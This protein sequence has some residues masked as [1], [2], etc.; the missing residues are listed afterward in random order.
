[1]RRHSLR[2]RRSPGCCTRCRGS[3]AAFVPLNTRLTAAERR[4]QLEDCGA[5]LVLD[6]PPDG[7]EADRTLA[8]G[9]DAASALAVLYTSGT[10]AQPKQVELTH[11]NFLASALASAANLGVEPDDR[12]LCPMPLFHVGG[13]SILVR[14]AIYG[15][16]A[17]L[18]DGFDAAA[19]ADSLAG[20]EATIV[21]LVATML[22]RLRDAGLDRTPR[23]RA[24]LIGGGPVPQGPA[25]VGRGAGDSPRPDLRPDRDDIAGRDDAPRGRRSETRLGR[26]ATARSPAACRRRWG[27]SGLRSDGDR[28]RLATHRRPGSTRCRG[29]PLRRGTDKGHD[30]VRRRERR[31]RGGGGGPALASGSS[32]CRRGGSSRSGVGG[33]GNGFRRRRRGL[34]RLLLAHC[35]ERLAGYKLPREIRWIAEIPRT[36]SGKTLRGRLP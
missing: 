33:G 23:L 6:A 8:T 25:G 7:P 17:V 15:T 14:S 13:L 11:A 9:A 30:R 24:A 35:R 12:W 2:A 22:R 32:R 5:R 26:E 27:D 28:R 19:V 31:R 36:A 1:M 3:S 10:T 18:H 34:R 20:G 29:L 16:A 21:S 4:W